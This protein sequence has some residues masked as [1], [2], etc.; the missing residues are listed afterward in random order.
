MK[1][2][3]KNLALLGFIV[4][5]LIIGINKLVNVISNTNDNLPIGKGKFFNWKYGDIYY[6]KSGKGKPILL[7]HDLNVCSSSY[8]WKK[9]IQKLSRTNTVYA[10][11]LLGCGRSDKPNLTYSNYL[12]VQLM[13]EFIK[14]V[15]GSRT[16]VIATG[17]S[18]SFTIMAC[19]MEEEN[20]NRIIGVSPCDIY[21]MA[22][23]PN[24]KKNILKFLMEFPVF[25]TFTYN[26]VTSKKCVTDKMV[27]EYFYKSHL[28]SKEDI[29]AYF[30]AAKTYDGCGKYLLA[31][32]K[33]N[34]TNINIIPAVEKINQSICLIAGKEHP[35][36]N[37]II[38]E[39]KEYNPSIEAAYIA[40]TD[41]LP[42]LESPDKF[43]ELINIILG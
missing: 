4:T 19:Q 20:F 5:G 9:V 13:N 26:L 38:E 30:K 25:G 28:V 6:T 35:Y 27:D 15:I 37:D 3:I 1:K 17:K 2:H 40:N 32:I 33:S 8:E 31:S 29:N 41:Y 23:T 18:L 7:V 24:K 42:Q 39:Y 36:M 34:Y 12:Y 22:K 11:D 16:T 43:V 10:I 21:D 14:K